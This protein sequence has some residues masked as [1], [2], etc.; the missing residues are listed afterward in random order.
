[1]VWKSHCPN[2]VRI[3]AAKLMAW[4]W[5]THQRMRSSR[6]SRRLLLRPVALHL[7]AHS[8]VVI[9]TLDDLCANS[10]RYRRRGRELPAAKNPAPSTST[11]TTGSA[12]SS[13]PETP[14]GQ[15]PRAADTSEGPLPPRSTPSRTASRHPNQPAPNTVPCEGCP[16]QSSSAIAA[17]NSSRE[18]ISSFW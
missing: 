17:L 15:A 3:R 11:S 4:V 16:D 2:R 1:M 5:L 7:A 6:F 18:R 13:S 9:T 8:G 14:W 10:D 12:N